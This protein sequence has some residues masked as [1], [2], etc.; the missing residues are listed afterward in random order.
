MGYRMW[1]HFPA[2]LARFIELYQWDPSG[3]VVFLESHDP[4][5]TLDA[6]GVALKEL[7]HAARAST[8][9]SR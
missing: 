1:S 7:Q 5:V 6:E 3:V 8:L 2:V 4:T 9:Q